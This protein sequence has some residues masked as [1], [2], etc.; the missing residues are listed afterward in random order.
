MEPK[1]GPRPARRKDAGAQEVIGYILTFFLS[2]VVLLFSMNAF[3]VTR[4]GSQALQSA[5]ELELVADKVASNV[6]RF[7]EYA[8]SVP[9]ATASTLLRL[10]RLANVDYYVSIGADNVSVN[11]TDGNIRVNATTFRASAVPGIHIAGRTDV[12]GGLV[13][14][15][16]WFNENGDPSAPGFTKF[17]RVL[18]ARQSCGGS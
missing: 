17:V 5:V 10:P 15:C 12:Q 14:L 6:A 2:S 4:G 9:N 11:T 8:Q 7:A 13:K 1:H 18:D 16:Y 3:T